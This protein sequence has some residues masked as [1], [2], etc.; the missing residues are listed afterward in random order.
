M[1]L[2]G[3]AAVIVADLKAK[4]VAKDREIQALKHALEQTS[5]VTS[6]TLQLRSPV[7]E[8]T[9]FDSPADSDTTVYEELDRLRERNNALEA[10]LKEMES[11]MAN[12]R[13]QVEKDVSG[14]YSL[15]NFTGTQ[16]S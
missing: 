8:V 11:N 12:L 6:S 2:S 10:S 16:V 4:L 5:P 7:L 15:A 1:G 9:Q 13:T 3:G 14:R